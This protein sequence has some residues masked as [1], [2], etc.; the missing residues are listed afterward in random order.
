MHARQT[1]A[2]I[3]VDMQ[4]VEWTNIDIVFSHTGD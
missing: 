1:Q 2:I 3:K 4:R